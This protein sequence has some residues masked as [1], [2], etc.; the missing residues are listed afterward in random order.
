MAYQLAVT[1]MGTPHHEPTSEDTPVSHIILLTQIGTPILSS[2]AQQV[3]VNL[4]YDTLKKKLIKDN[5]WDDTTFNNV[6]WDSH[7]QALLSYPRQFR[8]SL[9]KLCH[10]FWNRNMQNKKFYGETSL[11][12]H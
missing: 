10:K 9:S 1:R 7:H 3:T 12:P 6:D 4:T 2:I 5:K 8:M 11:C